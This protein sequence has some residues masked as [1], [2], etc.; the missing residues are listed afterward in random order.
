MVD[1]N[2]DTQS[3]RCENIAMLR[4]VEES[5]GVAIRM[6]EDDRDRLDIARQLHALEHSLLT[7]K[8]R[9]MKEHQAANPVPWDHLLVPRWGTAPANGD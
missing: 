9:L 3:E 8:R 6:L 5:L 2:N 4:R 1:P 7:T